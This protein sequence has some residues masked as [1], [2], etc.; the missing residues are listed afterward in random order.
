[1]S[2]GAATCARFSLKSYL[3]KLEGSPRARSNCATTGSGIARS[4]PFDLGVSQFE[5][6][7]LTSF[8]QLPVEFEVLIVPETSEH[9]THYLIDG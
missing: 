7:S 5:Q 1:M 4:W 3:E 9:K 6:L 2:S 8:A